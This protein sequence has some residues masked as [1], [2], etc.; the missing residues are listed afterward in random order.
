MVSD[1]TSETIGLE[2]HAST[3]S[4]QKSIAVVPVP[5]H[6][7]RGKRSLQKYA[8]VQFLGRMRA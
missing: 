8:Y 4:C 1:G 6:R 5:D 7:L 2:V 3:S